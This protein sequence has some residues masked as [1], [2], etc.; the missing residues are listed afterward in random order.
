MEGCQ[1]KSDKVTFSLS[2]LVTSKTET[3]CIGESYISLTMIL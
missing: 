3:F 1:L 2:I